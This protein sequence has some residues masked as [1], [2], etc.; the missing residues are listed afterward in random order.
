MS[1]IYSKDK[2]VKIID[3]AN[4]KFDF[5]RIGGTKGISIVNNQLQELKD[6]L[7]GEIDIFF[8]GLSKDVKELNI[9][10]YFE[11]QQVYYQIRKILLKFLPEQTIKVIGSFS[12]HLN[13]SL[14]NEYFKPSDIDIYIDSVEYISRL[15]L[16]VIFS[17]IHKIIQNNPEMKIINT[18]YNLSNDLSFISFI[19]KNIRI[20]IVH[21]DRSNSW[22]NSNVHCNIITSNFNFLNQILYTSIR[23]ISKLRSSNFSF[24]CHKW[25]FTYFFLLYIIYLKDNNIINDDGLDKQFDIVKLEEILEEKLVTG[26]ITDLKQKVKLF[27]DGFIKLKW[28]NSFYN[29]KTKY[30]VDNVIVIK[31]VF[32]KPR[33]VIHVSYTFTKRILNIILQKYTNKT[34]AVYYHETGD[35]DSYKLANMHNS[36]PIDVIIILIN[37]DPKEIPEEFKIIQLSFSSDFLKTT[38]IIWSILSCFGDNKSSIKEYSSSSIYKITNRPKKTNQNCIICKSYLSSQFINLFNN[39]KN[40]FD[41]LY[42]LTYI[43]K[44]NYNII[45]NTLVDFYEISTPLEIKYFINEYFMQNHHEEIL[46]M[47]NIE[48]I[49]SRILFSSII[50]ISKFCIDNI[51]SIVN[52]FYDASIEE[53]KVNIL[54]QI[55]LVENKRL[56]F[57]IFSN[58]DLITDDILPMQHQ[59]KKYNQLYEI[60]GNII[61]NKNNKLIDINYIYKIH[62]FTSTSSSTSSTKII[63][64]FLGDIDQNGYSKNL[65]NMLLE[66]FVFNHGKN[67]CNN[68]TIN[69]NIYIN[70]INFIICIFDKI[71]IFINKIFIELVDNLL[72]KIKEQFRSIPIQCG[73]LNYDKK[74]TL[75]KQIYMKNTN[76]K[77]KLNKFNSLF[78]LIVNNVTHCNKYINEIIVIHIV[79][80]NMIFK[81]IYSYTNFWNIISA[82]VGNYYFNI[83]DN[84][85]LD[86]SIHFI[87]NILK[88]TPVNC[89]KDSFVK[90]ALTYY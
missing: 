67:L 58:K 76:G 28:I 48:L 54:K 89:N 73:I 12:Q 35:S 87:E 60:F 50:D 20:E 31:R 64:S 65:D 53:I 30:H 11:T 7:P 78:E 38:N 57:N 86:D 55:E 51:F 59:L 83:T 15:D 84:I 75:L 77:N 22:I 32:S 21:K 69:K 47:N 90:K 17:N 66:I 4:E 56:E 42:N 29:K 62:K 23:K 16:L 63:T 19:Y 1:F 13:N 26:E 39:K 70:I 34:F 80:N 14:V 6:I 3:F 88:I 81:T 33:T 24:G 37:M 43:K 2:D 8:L 10:T 79:N 74:F 82:Y 18:H 36:L 71:H 49:L 68:K 9:L 85:L 41:I 61:K 45:Y 27:F 46:H 52:K 25:D 72:L 44:N 40:I 5:N